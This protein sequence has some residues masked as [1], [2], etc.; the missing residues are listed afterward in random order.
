[1]QRLIVALLAFTVLAGHAQTPANRE[2]AIRAFIKTF[3]DARNAHDGNSVAALYTEDGEWIQNDELTRVRGRANLAKLWNG[4][5]GHVDRTINAIEFPGPDIATVRVSCQY[6]PDTGITGLH[7][8]VFVLVNE[9]VTK[10]PNW[11]IFV[12]QTLN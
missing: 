5:T 9:S 8:E 12:H 4:I 11:R 6:H 10:S 7:S 2:D 3:G 1:M